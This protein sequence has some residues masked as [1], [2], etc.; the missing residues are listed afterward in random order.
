M[1]F[2]FISLSTYLCYLILKYQK[3]LALFKREKY[4]VKDYGKYLLKHPK[5]IFLTPEV[6]ALIVI[7]LAINTD[8]KIAG[9][10]M[11]VFYMI[12]FL[13]E[14]KIFD[15]KVKLDIN[16]IRIL[17]IVLLIYIGLS[18]WFVVDYN[19]LQS[20]FL[21]FDHRWIYYIIVIILGYFS[22]FVI[23][24]G[25]LF[26]RLI[27]KLIPTKQKKKSAKKQK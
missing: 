12:M 19:A 15:K 9:I 13:Y 21:I 22:Y 5:E 24:L 7:A 3:G 18:I 20:G 6:L 1:I 11:V 4:V 2:F 10:S 14:L 16:M 8:A 27:I 25:G 23:L 17:T 26:N